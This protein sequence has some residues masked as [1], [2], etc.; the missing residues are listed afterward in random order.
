MHPAAVRPPLLT[1][2]GCSVQTPRHPDY[3]RQPGAP[4]GRDGAA[5]GD[6]SATGQRLQIRR[7]P[8]HEQEHDRQSQETRTGSSPAQEPEAP[9]A[10]CG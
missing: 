2:H 4:P 3:P 10:L 8:H 6:R 9:T 7:Q 5:V 1:A